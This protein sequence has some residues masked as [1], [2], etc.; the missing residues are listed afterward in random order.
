M[1]SH[2]YVSVVVVYLIAGCSTAADQTTPPR[3]SNPPA[4]PAPAPTAPPATSR[5][6]DM[7]KG[8]SV[9]PDAKMV[10]DFKAR[11]EEYEKLRAKA[12]DTTPKLKETEKPADI[13]VAEKSLAEGIRTA[14]ASAKRGDIFTPATQAMFRRLLRP[15][16][17]GHEGTENKDLLKDDL[18]E[19]KDVPFK[20]NGEYP[21]TATVST[22]PPDLLL[23]LPTLPKDIEYRFVGK[24][25]ILY[26]VK[27]NL[28]IDFMLNALP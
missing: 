4:S 7:P 6:P 16:L 15:P 23:Q 2:L 13:T 25:L 27:A 3:P 17:K 12:D 5:K 11:V 22:V 1:K 20:I 9:S 8:S 24:H 14:R 10:A 18:P 19:P 28:I 26:D 21:K